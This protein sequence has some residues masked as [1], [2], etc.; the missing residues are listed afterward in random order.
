MTRELVQPLSRLRG[1]QLKL[2]LSSR[3]QTECGSAGSNPIDAQLSLTRRYR[4][5]LCA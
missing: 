4:A 1:P 3:T 2:R 5:R